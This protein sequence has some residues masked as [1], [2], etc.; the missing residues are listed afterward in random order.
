MNKY[1]SLTILALTVA[2]SSV[3]QAGSKNKGV[4]FRDYADVIDV[5]PLVRLVEVSNPRKE[6]WQE[7]V[8]HPVSSDYPPRAAGSMILGGLVGGVI[9]HQFGGGHG[10]D[11]A[12]LAGTLVGASVGHDL[13]NRR[14]R[15]RNTHH[16]SYEQQCRV[17]HDV[18]SEERID[19]YR[20]TYSYHGK[21]FTTRL[22]YDPGHRLPMR[23]RITPVR[24]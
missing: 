24:H 4:S 3:G 2:F 15:R 12:T 7:E 1:I 18:H 9:G 14:A 8:H 22:P 5:E 23:V 11:L 6:C 17:V 19:G 10:K 21:T 13:A 16:I 20:V